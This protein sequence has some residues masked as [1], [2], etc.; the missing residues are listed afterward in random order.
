[1]RANEAMRY[2]QQRW[3]LERVWLAVH[4][5]KDIDREEEEVER[6]SLDVSKTVVEFI[7]RIAAY[8]NTLAAIQGKKLKRKWTRKALAE[9]LL[10]IQVAV[11]REQFAQMVDACGELPPADDAEAMERYVRKVMAWDKRSNNS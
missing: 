2:R 5:P 8:R 6:L 3:P 1:M 11:L 4:G 7:T 10:E 9:S